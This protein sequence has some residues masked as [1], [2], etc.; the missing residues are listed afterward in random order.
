MVCSLEGLFRIVVARKHHPLY[1]SAADAWC[2]GRVR[3]DRS[4]SGGEITISA[5]S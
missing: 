3:N 1:Q 2:S 4:V 5:E